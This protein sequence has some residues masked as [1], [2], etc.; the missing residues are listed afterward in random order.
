MRTRTPQNNRPRSITRGV[1]ALLLVGGCA[2]GT[3]LVS[4]MG[5]G[6][7]VRARPAFDL[8]DADDSDGASVGLTD[9][10][11]ATRCN[12]AVR[13]RAPIGCDYGIVAAA[14]FGGDACAAVLV[15][16]PGPQPARLSVRRG[17][18][19]FAIQPATRQILGKG[20][21]P[22]WG[23]LENDTLAPGASAAIFLVEGSDIGFVSVFVRCRPWSPSSL[24]FRGQA[25]QRSFT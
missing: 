15:S 12:E 2:T 16:N 8:P 13:I 23:D 22:E 17:E 4:S 20:L 6:D 1:R 18:K 25:R 7:E 14:H 3:T 24:T 9:A 5:C 11:P 10:G 21:D 19:A